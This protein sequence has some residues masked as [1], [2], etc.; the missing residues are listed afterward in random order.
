MVISVAWLTLSGT[1]IVVVTWLFMLKVIHAQSV[2][3]AGYA[4]VILLCYKSYDVSKRQLFFKDT[5]SENLYSLAKGKINLITANQSTV[6]INCFI[7]SFLFI[8]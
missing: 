1:M 8:F 4:E 2:L 7:H 5:H 3:I 6:P